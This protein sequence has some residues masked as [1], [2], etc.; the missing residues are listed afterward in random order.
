MSDCKTYWLCIQVGLVL[1][2]LDIGWTVSL[3]GSVLALL[4][5]D[6]DKNVRLCILTIC[7]RYTVGRTISLPG[8]LGLNVLLALCRSMASL[9]NSGYRPGCKSYWL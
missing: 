2:S 6:I 7:S 5:L 9:T 4:T 3:A 8:S 1:L